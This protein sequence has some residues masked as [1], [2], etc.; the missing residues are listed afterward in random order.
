[1][2]CSQP[3]PHAD[4]GIEQTG[5]GETALS[6]SQPRKMVIVVRDLRVAT[7]L[8]VMLITEIRFFA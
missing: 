7:A 1:M 6:F 8:C 4:V 3:G 5:G 2:L